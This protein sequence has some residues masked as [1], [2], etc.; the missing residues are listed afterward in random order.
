MIAHIKGIL[1]SNTSTE[2]VIDCSGVGYHIFIPVTT[3]EV[4]PATGEQVILKTHMITKE[5]SMTLYGF[6]TDGEREAFK[7]LISVSGIG[8]KIALGILSS[9]TFSELHEYI[10]Q[11]NTPALQKLPGI[12][13]KTAERLAL[14]LA[15]KINNLGKYFDESIPSESNV[16]KN[17][18]LSALVALGYSA[19]LAEKF[20]KAAI[21]D[22]ASGI[23]AEDLIRK[24][25]NKAM[26]N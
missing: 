15:D 25:L 19:S 18:A 23:S 9:V 22:S 21:K 8:P 17:E 6:I 10:I 4:L 1:S 16:A 12:G 14:E 3:S 11:K 26:S 20:V 2:A 7:L 5:D 24:A 13:K